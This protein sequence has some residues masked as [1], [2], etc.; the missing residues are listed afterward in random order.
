MRGERGRVG[1]AGVGPSR[2]FGQFRQDGPG[3]CVCRALGP[4][5]RVGGGGGGGD[6]DEGPGHRRKTIRHL[7]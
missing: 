6:G 5:A 4:L 1:G 7:P 3:I 2:W